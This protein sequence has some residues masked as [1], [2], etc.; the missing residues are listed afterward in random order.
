MGSELWTVSIDVG[1]TFTDAIGRR[2]DGAMVVAKVPSTPTDPALGLSSAVMSLIGQGVPVECI[3]LVC[4][5]TT[6]AT[7]AVLTN[8]LAKV[9]LVTT[10]GFRDVLAY[11][12]GSRPQVY[13]LTPERPQDL[14]PRELRFEVRERMSSTGEIVT[15]LTDEA[16]SRLV[17]DVVESKPEAIAVCLL[18]DFINDLNEQKVGMALRS[19]LPSV[20]VTLASEIVREFREYPRTSTAVINAALRPLVSE[21]LKHAGHALE[22]LG[23]S[24]RLLVMQSN[25][26]CAP[27][28]RAQHEAHRL[29]LSGPAGGVSGLIRLSRAHGVTN[30]ISLDMGGTSTDVC[31][32]RDGSVPIATTQHIRDHQVLAPA[33]DIHTI[34]AGGGSIAWVDTTGCLRVGPSSAKAE[35]GPVSSGRGGNQPT[36]T[37]AHVVLGT[38]GSAT[39][40][41]G[42]NLD[43]EAAVAALA[44][45]GNQLGVTGINAKAVAQDTAHSIVAISVAHMVRALRKVSIERGLDPREFT[46]V[47]F[48]GAG[49][50]HAGLLIRHLQL[51]DAII[52]LRP[53]LFSAEGLVSAGLRLDDSQTVL[54]IFAN[55]F[56]REAVTWF[57]ERIV[58]LTEQLVSDGV[59]SRSVTIALVADCRYVGQ[60]YELPTLLP[61]ASLTDMESLPAAFHALHRERYGHSNESED[62]EVVTL[63]IA[64]FGGIDAEREKS[65]SAGNRKPPVEAQLAVEN[66]LVPGCEQTSVSV[67][68]RDALLTGNVLTG[69][70]I[71]HQM[72]ATTLILDG[73][74]ASV[75]QLGDL[76]IEEM[77]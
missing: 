73:Q 65:V 31:L 64:A 50:L 60:G 42:M 35:P 39:L 19:A 49:P 24:G 75:I 46:L 77:R 7:N 14:V 28:S 41:G 4:H 63:R 52:P 5:G 1:G 3:N 34:G 15:P 62:I 36:L 11:R 57:E 72:D 54:R 44:A 68:N 56:P 25:G 30:V 38:L 12:N 53:G 17:E 37:D 26:G 18:F 71:I 22:E 29:I 47:P 33:V 6:V 32:V 8:S 59:D 51:R 66:I 61:G 55:D 13:S 9:A 40:A 43:R 2:S 21:Y 58:A 70:A 23:I 20:P 27:V 74:Q 16:V 48:G 10:E 45:L 76:R 69:P 67:W